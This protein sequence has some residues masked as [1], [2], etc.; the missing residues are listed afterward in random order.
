M[1]VRSARETNL[2]HSLQLWR[3]LAVSSTAG[4]ER[5]TMY[6]TGVKGSRAV[7]GT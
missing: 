1:L 4:L 5:Q 7:H 6:H 3:D 2:D